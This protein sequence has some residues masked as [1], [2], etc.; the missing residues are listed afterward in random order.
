MPY[1]K[2]TYRR[3]RPRRAKKKPGFL[4]T[5]GSGLTKSFPLGKSFKWHTRYADTNFVLAPTVSQQAV[6]HVFSMNG[7]YDPDVTGVGHQPLGF[8][9]LVGTMYDHYTVV[10]ARAKVVASN[11]SESPQN[12]L[13]QLKD[14][15]TT[16]TNMSEIIENGTSVYG[17]LGAQDTGTSVRTFSINCSL[18]KFFGRKVL[19]DDKY[20][21]NA[22]N[23][24]AD[25]VYLHVITQPQIAAVLGVVNFSITIEYI[26]ILTEPRQLSTS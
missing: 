1:R 10:G 25:Q 14:T 4:K 3:R 12:F 23:N 9:Q 8:D 13:L 16:S 17:T 24:P 7:M 6:T 2:K 5:K 18:S 26:T 21:G 20:E 22:G 11:L 19:Q 15:T